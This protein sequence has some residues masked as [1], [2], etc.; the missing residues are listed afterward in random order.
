MSPFPNSPGAKRSLSHALAEV[1]SPTTRPRRRVDANRSPGYMPSSPTE[2]LRLRRVATGPSSRVA[3]ERVRA[4][5]DRPVK[6]R[7]V[8]PLLASLKGPTAPSREETSGPSRRSPSPPASSVTSRNKW[9][10]DGVEIETLND[11]KRR[12]S[13][14][15]P[16]TP[17]PV[18]TTAAPQVLSPE[19]PSPTIAATSRA[20]SSDDYDAWEIPIYPDDDMDV[21][22]DSQPS[23]D[24]DDDDSLLPSF[25]KEHKGRGE[26][27]CDPD[28]LDGT[29]VPSSKTLGK[30]PQHTARTQTAP[31]SFLREDSPDA[32][33]EHTAPAPLQR[34]RT[35]FAQLEGLQAVCDALEKDGSQLDWDQMVAMTAL[36][37]RV[38]AVMSEKMSKKLPSLPNGGRKTDARGRGG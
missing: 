8:S 6:R 13:T 14:A 32:E 18:E 34:A 5:R 3:H 36:N 20:P 2:T 25:M 22:A 9:R 23:D 26:Q 35:A 37:H 38:G 31:P 30:R 24:K 17:Q 11:F 27:H 10:F 1:D 12:T 28:N 15:G 7:K 29:P 4:T 19:V 16:S 21:V 33:R